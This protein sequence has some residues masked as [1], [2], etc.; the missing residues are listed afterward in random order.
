MLSKLKPET[1]IRFSYLY[2]E[3]EPTNKVYLVKEGVFVITKKLVY[4]GG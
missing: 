1:K 3:G 4:L 2:R